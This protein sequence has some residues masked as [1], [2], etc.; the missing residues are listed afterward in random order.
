MHCTQ[1]HQRVAYCTLIL[2]SFGS[3]SCK[4]YRRCCVLPFT[5]LI[6][7]FIL[8]NGATKSHA[9][10]TVAS[11]CRLLYTQIYLV[12]KSGLYVLKAPM[13]DLVHHIRATSIPLEIEPQTLASLHILGSACRL[14]PLQFCLVCKTDTCHVFSSTSGTFEY[15]SSNLKFLPN[16]RSLTFMCFTI[17]LVSQLCIFNIFSPWLGDW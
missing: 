17:V 7:H 1:L 16:Q 4:Y 14:A 13:I 6:D 3:L 5:H 10:H 2:T 11:A 8:R 12:W 9:M 15:F